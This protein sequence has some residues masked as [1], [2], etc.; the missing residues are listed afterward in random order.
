MPGRAVAPWLKAHDITPDD[1][2]SVLGS[3]VAEGEKMISA[4]LSSNLY[5]H[6]PGYVPPPTKENQLNKNENHLL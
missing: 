2:S 1:Q 5:T 3:H 6:A 4:Q